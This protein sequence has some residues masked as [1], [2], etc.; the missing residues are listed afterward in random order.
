MLR[1]LDDLI[2]PV[3]GHDMGSEPLFVGNRSILARSRLV[4]YRRVSN[5]LRPNLLDINKMF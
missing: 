2:D 4:G 3:D 1:Y 5:G